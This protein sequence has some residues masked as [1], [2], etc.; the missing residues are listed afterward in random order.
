VARASFIGRSL[1]FLGC[2]YKN[3][4]LL[5]KIR[6]LRSVFLLENLR[7]METFVLT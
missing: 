5:D 3:Y 4:R 1:A 6:A 7:L 2:I